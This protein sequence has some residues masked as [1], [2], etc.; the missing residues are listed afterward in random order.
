M[1]TI[2]TARDS[3]WGETFARLKAMTGE[4]RYEEALTEVRRGTHRPPRYPD[5][6]PDLVTGEARALLAR[7]TGEDPGV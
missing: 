1:T 3:R 6:Y 5:G 2:R 7:I 4:G